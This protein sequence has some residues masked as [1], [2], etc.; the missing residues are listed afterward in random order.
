MPR[1]SKAGGGLM[2]GFDLTELPVLQEM[3][4]L[5]QLFRIALAVGRHP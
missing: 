3:D 2:P 1:V 4:D 5:V